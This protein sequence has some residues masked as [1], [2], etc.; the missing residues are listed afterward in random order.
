MRYHVE[1]VVRGLEL[2]EDEAQ[3]IRERAEHLGHFYGR[4]HRCRVTLEG[5]RPHHRLGPCRMRI[6][7]S[8]PGTVLVV[9]RQSG[10][11]PALAAREAF[12]AAGRRLE[13]YVRRTRGF[14]KRRSA[15]ALQ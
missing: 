12:S 6:D 4:I 10:E 13:D 3:E 2:S 15:Q 9:N 5:P 1:L 8:L 11:T 7:L 14:V